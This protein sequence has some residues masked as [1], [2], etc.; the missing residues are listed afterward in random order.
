MEDNETFE[1]PRRKVRK[2]TYVLWAWIILIIV[3]IAVGAHNAHHAVQQA[4]TGQTYQQLC[5]S[6]GDTGTAIGVGVIIMIGFFGFI[7]LSLIWLM[8]K[9]R[10][11]A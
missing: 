6:A 7:V 11:A 5:Q 9:P 8:T 10:D 1:P 2:M 4:C 3:W